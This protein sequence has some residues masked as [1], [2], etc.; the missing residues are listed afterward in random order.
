L[1]TWQAQPGKQRSGRRKSAAIRPQ[2][3]MPAS[4]GLMGFFTR[5]PSADQLGAADI[6]AIRSNRRL[7]H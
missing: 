2:W 3:Q 4:V 7:A 5:P 6:A 1:Q